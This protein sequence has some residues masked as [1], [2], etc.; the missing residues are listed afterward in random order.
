MSYLGRGRLVAV[1]SCFCFYFV[2]LFSTWRSLFWP[3]QWLFLRRLL[4]WLFS[5]LPSSQQFLTILFSF[6]FFFLRVADLLSWK[7]VLTSCEL[8]LWLSPL[9]WT[10]VI[11]FSFYTGFALTFYL[12]DFYFYFF[13][14]LLMG[15]IVSI[16]CASV[17]W[18]INSCL[19][20]DK[21]CFCFFG[22]C[23]TLDMICVCVCI[24]C[25]YHQRLFEIWQWSY[26][27]HILWLR[28]L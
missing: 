5:S 15:Y 6:S 16:L 9:S 14:F 23:F 3:W 25:L 12:Y 1:S 22:G 26:F 13:S 4:F 28:F 2:N 18:L 7:F 20:F 27:F 8:W 17:V 10:I 21:N 24:C 11:I 19:R